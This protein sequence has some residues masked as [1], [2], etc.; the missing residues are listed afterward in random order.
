M[1]IAA[2]YD[3]DSTPDPYT[4]GY[5]AHSRRKAFHAPTAA[6]TF[7]NPIGGARAAPKTAFANGAVPTTAAASTGGVDT[8]T[9]TVGD[10]AT[11]TD[12]ITVGQATPTVTCDT[13]PAAV[14]DGAPSLDRDATLDTGGG[15]GDHNVTAVN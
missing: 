7:N 5:S 12:Y 15:T 1:L 2:S 3:R 6:V 9:A 14:T 13:A 8:R 10:A 4:S 11:I